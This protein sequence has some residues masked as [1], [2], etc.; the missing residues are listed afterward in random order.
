MFYNELPHTIFW[1]KDIESDSHLFEPF[2]FLSHEINCFRGVNRGVVVLDGK[3]KSI[4]L[5]CF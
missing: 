5:S 1:I 2:L 3:R 4:L